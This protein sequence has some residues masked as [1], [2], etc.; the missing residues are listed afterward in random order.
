MFLGDE[1]ILYPDC[2]KGYITVH[3]L[4]FIDM[5]TEIIFIVYKFKNTNFKKGYVPY[6]TERLLFYFLI[7]FNKEL[8]NKQVDGT[9]GFL[10]ANSCKP[11]SFLQGCI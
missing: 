10:N 5:W 9:H 4:K 2:G 7:T 11:S 3:M 8:Q 1:I 6:K